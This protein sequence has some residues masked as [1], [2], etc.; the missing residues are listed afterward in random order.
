M[1]EVRGE[2]A[3]FRSCSESDDDIETFANSLWSFLSE[4]E[5][6]GSELN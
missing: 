4:N 2:D 6:A 5:F 3:D 1:L